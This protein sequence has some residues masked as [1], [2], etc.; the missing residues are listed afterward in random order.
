[1]LAG[2]P[3]VFLSCSERY[4]KTVGHP[5][6]LILRDQHGINAII[7]S[8]EPMPLGISWEPDN[9]VQSYVSSSDAFVALCTPDNAHEDGRFECRQNI[10]DEIRLARSMPHLQH[11][12][13]VLKSHEVKLPSNIN[14][15]YENLDVKDATDV[16]PIIVRQLQEW[17]VLSLSAAVPI[18]V[19]TESSSRID[20]SIVTKL[21]TGI[22]LGGH[23]ESRYRAYKLMLSV[24]KKDQ[25]RIAEAIFEYMTSRANDEDRHEELLIA[26]SFLEAMNKHDT[27]LVPYSVIELMTLSES[28]SIRSSAAILLWD[29]ATATPGT[30]PLD[31]VGRLARPAD[32]DWYV[33]AP[34][35]AAT[36]LLVLSRDDAYVILENLAESEDV[37]DRDAVI[38]A[39]LG[40]AKVNPVAVNPS[41][42][43]KLFRDSEPSIREGAQLA[44]DIIKDIGDGE[45]VRR[46][47]PFGL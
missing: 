41:L 3:T 12:V 25:G 19:N 43:E 33:S 9:K 17:G 14:P 20:E 11:K 38:T 6:K 5:I 16:V 22:G 47:S 37:A 18:T 44:M 42:V 4:R 26:A 30:V 27:S 45:H 24:S 32:E 10:I 36:K 46:L 13:M 39:L 29:K 35:M 34:A 40:I 28:F 8:E 23:E 21:L 15:T 2:K 7:V 31:L 1:M